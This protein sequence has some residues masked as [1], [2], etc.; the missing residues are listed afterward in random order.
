MTDPP[1][2]ATEVITA[3][4]GVIIDGIELMTAG[5]EGIGASTTIV[6]ETAATGEML[7]FN[8][9]TVGTTMF[10]TGQTEGSMVVR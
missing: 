4:I 1:A 10:A 9:A 6:S 2:G 7:D 8:G 5:I 3:G